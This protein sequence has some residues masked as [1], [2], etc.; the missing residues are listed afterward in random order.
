[1][2]RL[3]VLLVV[4]PLSAPAADVLRNPSDEAGWHWYHEPE[5]PEEEAPA[6]P[7][8]MSPEARMAALQQETK[9]ALAA[10]IMTPTVENFARFKRL[11]DFWT[12]RAGEFSMVAQKAMLVH[13]ELDYN[14]Q[15]SHYNGTARLQQSDDRR[16]ERKAIASLAE[17]YGVFLFYRGGE[18]ADA[19]LAE[20]VKGF[21][22]E[23]G[24]SF[25]PVT[26]DGKASAT[27]PETRMNQG[28]AERLGVTHFPAL[29]LVDP[30]EGTAKPLA[31]G[32][33]SQD[34]LARRFLYVATDFKPNF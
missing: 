21:S 34:D 23:H 1:M 15:H 20:V 2:K 9:A 22:R 11:Q 19:Q 18:A 13:P 33:I 4:L 32:F 12:A 16:R 26:V 27:L 10:A 25:I 17:Q 30:R 28:Q 31:F 6:A 8:K 14:L 29:V 7:P 5:P 24:V 3:L